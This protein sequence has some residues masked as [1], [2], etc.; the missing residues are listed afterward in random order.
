MGAANQAFVPFHIH[1]DGCEGGRKVPKG[2]RGREIRERGERRSA[3]S[4]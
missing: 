2:T 1:F 4:P 3:P